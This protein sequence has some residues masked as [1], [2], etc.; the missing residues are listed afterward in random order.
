MVIQGGE[1]IKKIDSS[2]V[3]IVYTCT[4]KIKYCI[5]NCFSCPSPFC[6]SKSPVPLHDGQLPS[7]AYELHRP[8]PMHIA[9]HRLIL[10]PGY[11]FETFLDWPQ[12]I[13][14]NSA[15]L[16]RVGHRVAMSVCGDVCGDVCA[17]E[18]SFFRGLSLALRS[19]DQILASHWSTPPRP[20]LTT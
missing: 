17:I 12:V 7:Q 19:H 13:F 1:T 11:T 3:P 8:Q 15:P 4:Y 14:T 20:P 5:P 16:G 9:L 2:N 10:S 18:C 6:Q